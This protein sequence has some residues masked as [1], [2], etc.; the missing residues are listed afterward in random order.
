MIVT[1]HPND[2]GLGPDS[3][4]KITTVRCS[5]GCPPPG[6]EKQISGTK[7]YWSNPDDWRTEQD[8]ADGVPGKVPVAG[9]A[10]V[11]EDGWN[12]VYDIPPEQAVDLQKL[13]IIGQ[14]SFC[15]TDDEKCP[16]PY[17]YELRSHLILVEVGWLYIGDVER[18]YQ[19]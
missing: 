13:T 8:V 4:L 7:R 11:I 19:G 16:A 3:T 10:V 14:L 6:Q 15:E 12:M 18:P 2:A 17:K 1:A 5:D 9:D